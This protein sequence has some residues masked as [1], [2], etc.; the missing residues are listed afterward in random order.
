MLSEPKSGTGRVRIR[1]VSDAA[2]LLYYIYLVI[3][4]YCS[5]PLFSM[6]GLYYLRLPLLIEVPKS[7]WKFSVLLSLKWTVGE[8]RIGGWMLNTT[9]MS[10]IYTFIS[11]KVE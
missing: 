11:K 9:F 6:G 1:R 10:V 3:D 5:S 4:C 2:I 8:G 7:S